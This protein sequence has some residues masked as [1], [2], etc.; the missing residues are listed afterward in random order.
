M[1]NDTESLAEK[2]ILLISN[3]DLC[4]QLAKNSTE[5]VNSK[6]GIIDKYMEY[7]GGY[8]NPINKISS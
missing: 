1:I 7:L 6:I 5:V 2:V 3:T 8:L 4:N